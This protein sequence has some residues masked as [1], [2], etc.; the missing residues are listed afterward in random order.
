MAD[1]ENDP[2]TAGPPPRPLISRRNMLLGGALIGV[3][4]IGYAR[5]PQPIAKPLPKDA[6]DKLIPKQIGPWSFVTVSGVV[7][8]PDDN[9]D[10]VYDQVLTR[11]YSAP[12][13]PPIALLLAYSSVQNGLLQLHRPEICYPASGFR[14]SGTE[15]GTLSLPDRS[16][17]VRR[18]SASSMQRQERVLY[19]TRLGTEMPV[20]WVNQRLAVV[21]ANLRGEIPDGI[22]VRVSGTFSGT[23]SIDGILSEFVRDLAVAL[24]PDARKLLFGG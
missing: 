10:Q 20:S 23:N 3:S 12:N 15:P 18:F 22:L 1:A 6:L 11:M 17:N 24:R 19:W 4:A 5:Q 7:L 16:I 8:P 13:Q 21:R 14:L 9:S 2:F